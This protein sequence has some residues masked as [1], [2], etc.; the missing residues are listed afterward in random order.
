MSASKRLA[1]EY[2]S[3]QTDPNP[4]LE[5]LGPETDNNMFKWK[6][7]MRGPQD[8]PY[9]GMFESYIYLYL[10]WVFSLNLVL[11]TSKYKSS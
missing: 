9:E 1:K 11:H 4:A 7:V 3:S 10:L 6:A 2:I 8:S 5:S